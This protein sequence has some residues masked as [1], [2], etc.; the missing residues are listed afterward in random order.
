M[1][2]VLEV[3][4]DPKGLA[5]AVKLNELELLCFHTSPEA[6][7]TVPASLLELMLKRDSREDS[8]EASLPGIDQ[9]DKQDC[10]E[11][12]L[13]WCGELRGEDD[14]AWLDASSAR[15][16]LRAAGGVAGE[17]AVFLLHGLKLAGT[18]GRRFSLRVHRDR[19]G[20]RDCL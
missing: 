5:P 3:G 13:L 4:S 9:K 19:L 20:C 11:G 12:W 1:L 15:L 17:P 8:R 10:C 16:S 2:G 7:D 14:A 6:P 18:V